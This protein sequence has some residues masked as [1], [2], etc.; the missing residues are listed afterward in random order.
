MMLL[1]SLVDLTILYVY[2]GSRLVFSFAR[3]GRVDCRFET[4]EGAR[5]A[6]FRPL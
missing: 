6:L 3:D 5:F 2:D 1:L 4:V